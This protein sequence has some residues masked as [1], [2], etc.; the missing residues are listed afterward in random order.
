MGGIVIFTEDT[1]ER[2]R[3]ERELQQARKIEALGQLTGGIAHDFNNML[4]SVLSFTQ[5]ALDRGSQLPGEKTNEYLGQIEIAARRGANLV[6]QMLTFARSH[7]EQQN[8]PLDVRP[9]VKEAV[10]MLSSV[11]PSSILIDLEIGAD[12]Y[13]KE[14]DP[15]QFH[16]VLMN[17]CVNARD[18]MSGKGQLRIRL[19]N[20]SI[21]HQECSACQKQ[22]SGDWLELSVRDSGHGMDQQTLYKIFDPFFTKDVDKGTGMG[23]S[24]VHGIVRKAKG[25]IMLETQPGNGAC[26]CILLPRRLTSEIQESDDKPRT[27]LPGGDGQ[28]IM[29]VDDEPA[30][31]DFLSEIIRLNGYRPV[32]ITDSLSAMELLMDSTTDIELL[33]TDQTMPDMTGIELASAIR[34]QRPTLLVILCSGYSEAVSA[35]TAAAH[36]IDLYLEKPIDFHALLASIATLLAR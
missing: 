12:P 34:T 1:T 18:A 2:T 7:P 28:A 11:L 33:I 29:V 35:A 22:V 10:K 32:M 31:A 36:D 26:F 4:A 23:H 20:V 13:M 16:Q 9:L 6:A 5:L 30:L 17:L 21:D 25:H 3:L 19:G 15:V 14:I 27:A 24:V 8:T